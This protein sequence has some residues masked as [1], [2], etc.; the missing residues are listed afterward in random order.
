[1][2]ANM[3]PLILWGIVTLVGAFVG[4]FLGSYLKKKGENLAT[5]EDVDKLVDQMKAVTQATKEIEAK[6]SSDVW[7]RQKRWEMKREVLFA[8]AKVIAEIDDSLVGFASVF[9]MKQEPINL[10]L[11]EARADRTK[12]WSHAWLKFEETRLL[13]EMVCKRETKEAFDALAAVTAQIAADVSKTA[14]ESYQRSSKEVAKR[15]F[16]VR[17]A[18]RKELEVDQAI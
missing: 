6:I 4:S 9:G 3:Q 14:G 17:A 13:V 15:I 8:A 1:M 12:R 18:M 11:A 5:H 10:Q 7:D 2:A 16:D